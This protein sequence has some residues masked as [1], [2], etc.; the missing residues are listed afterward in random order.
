MCKRGVR[1]SGPK[2]D[3]DLPQ[4]S[5]IGQFCL[6]DDILHAFYEPYLSM[7]WAKLLS[8]CMVPQAA[9]FAVV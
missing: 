5:F 2:A 4:S 1:G 7:G 8:T 3:K 9:C 6:D